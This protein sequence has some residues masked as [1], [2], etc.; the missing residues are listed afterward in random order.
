MLYCWM[1]PG[2]QNI[3]RLGWRHKLDQGNYWGQGV[4]RMCWSAPEKEFG[5]RTINNLVQFWLK[6]CRGFRAHGL[7]E[8]AWN[9]RFGPW[10]NLVRKCASS[11]KLWT[12]LIFCRTRHKESKKKHARYGH[13]KSEGIAWHMMWDANWNLVD[14]LSR[15]SSTSPV[16]IVLNS[17]GLVCVS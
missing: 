10:P 17:D 11:W 5:T 9:S 16:N 1:S 13:C 4:M 14:W 15:L 8:R 7:L 12:K 2:C 6:S 3:L